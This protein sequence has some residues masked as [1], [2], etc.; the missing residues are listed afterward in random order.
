MIKIIKINICRF[1]SII[2]LTVDI[3]QEYGLISICGKIMLEK[4]IH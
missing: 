4:Q 1:R 2:D 3:E